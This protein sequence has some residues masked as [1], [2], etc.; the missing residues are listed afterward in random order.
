M[1]QKKGTWLVIFMYDNPTLHLPCFVIC[2]RHSK[3][4]N[5]D[6]VAICNG[7]LE[8]R[9]RKFDSLDQVI[10]EFSKELKLKYP[11]PGSK[12]SKIQK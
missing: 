1:P 10:H 12:Y 2:S 6:L 8:F 3:Q 5:Y 11:C 7:K 4:V 9:N